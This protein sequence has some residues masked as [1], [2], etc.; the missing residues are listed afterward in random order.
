MEIELLRVKEA[1]GGLQN[2]PQLIWLEMQAEALADRE[3]LWVLHLNTQLEL[4]EKE[5]VS[6]GTL[7]S[8]IAHPREVFKKAILN[9][10]HSIITVHNHPSG[11][12]KPSAEDKK[13]WERFGEAGKI[14]GIPVIDNLIISARGYYSAS[15]K[16]W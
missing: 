15:E 13:A 8:S 2:S 1:Q 5:L 16:G 12:V 14:I 10:A 7:D 3:C 11:D 9:S 6:M 4:I